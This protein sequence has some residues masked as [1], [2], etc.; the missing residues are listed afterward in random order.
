MRVIPF[1][2]GSGGAG[3]GESWLA[4]LEAALD[5]TG[6][7]PRAESWRELRDEVRVLAPPMNPAF[8][9]ELGER[10]AERG[11][12]SAFGP[13][14]R[15]KRQDRRMSDPEGSSGGSSEGS[16]RDSRR[17]QHLPRWLHRRFGRLHPTPLGR[18][19]LTSPTLAG[20]A[21][22]FAVIAATLIVAPWRPAG[23]TVE[24]SP[25]STS[26]AVR[27]DELGPASGPAESA[28]ATGANGEKASS[29]GAEASASRAAGSV[30][31]TS[32]PTASGAA[33][34]PG[35]V[36]QLGA[37]ITLT[38]TPEEVQTV[39]DRVSRLT[40]SEGGFVQSSHVNE[41]EKTGEATLT[42][43]LPSAKLSA[44]LASLGQLAP[45]RSES[46]SLQDITNTYNEARQRLHDATAERQALLRAL[47]RASTEGEID[48][49]HA[50]L[51][52]NGGAIAQAR[53]ALGTV[54]K[55]A[56]TAE[57]EV[58]VVGDK[59]ASSEG[60]TLH[61][62]LHDAGRV[63]TVTFVVLLVA[64]ALLVPLALVAIA[65]ATAWQAW[66]RHQREGVLRGG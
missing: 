1:P 13:S 6:S 4:E 41:G 18:L 36:Q 39:A 20:V 23:H 47:A 57:V 43:S 38:A 54:A 21:V 24:S 12:R 34:A 48:S 45:V 22:A 52:Q 35:R 49:L 2:G 53:A 30:A 31:T 8:E 26:L 64:A 55:Q 14:H 56:S 58:T 63:L 16:S 25:R 5:G 19:R 3:P 61:R 50:R 62:G 60:L 37:S 46:Q 32:T 15:P 33:S 28:P 27:A 9:R 17:R 44:A 40:T 11:A 66:R 10:I 7:G 59:N 42:L 65:L 51:A 29:Q